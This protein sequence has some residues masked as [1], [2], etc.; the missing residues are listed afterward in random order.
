MSEKEVEYRDFVMIPEGRADNVRAMLDQLMQDSQTAELAGQAKMFVDGDKLVVP[1]GGDASA[2]LQLIE[3]YLSG[4]L[5]PNRSDA[6]VEERINVTQKPI[7]SKFVINARWPDE[8]PGNEAALVDEERAQPHRDLAP[9]VNDTITL[10]AK[11]GTIFEFT[12]GEHGIVNMSTQVG[13]VGEKGEDKGYKVSFA[14]IDDGNHAQW[15]SLRQLEQRMVTDSTLDVRAEL[16][17][18]L[19]QDQLTDPMIN[20]STEVET[21][22]DSI[23]DVD[24]DLGKDPLSQVSPNQTY[25]LDYEAIVAKAQTMPKQGNVDINTPIAGGEMLSQLAPEA[26]NGKGASQGVGA[27][28]LT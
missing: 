24:K 11:D 23:F 1:P 9:P 14:K 19:Q 15:A 12:Q 22:R 17:K 28:G 7:D 6:A 2:A 3:T 20:K 13:I 26:P 16:D 25:A 4:A 21:S 27:A 10:T 18:A 5:G 8:A